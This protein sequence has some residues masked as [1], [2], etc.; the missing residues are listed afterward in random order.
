MKTKRGLSGCTLKMIAVFIMVID[1]FGASIL[2]NFLINRWGASPIGGFLKSNPYYLSLIVQINSVIRKIGRPAFPIFCFFIVEGF[3][4]TRN[5][6][7]YAVRL[8]VFALISELPFD[9]ALY[10][11]FFYWRHQNVYFTLLLGLLLIWYLRDR[12]RY[13]ED[14]LIAVIAACCAA[15]I[16]HVDYGSF[17][18]A[19]IGIYYMLRKMP[20]FQATAGAVLSAWEMPAPIGSLMLLLYNGERG[21]QPKWFFYWFYPVHLFLYYAIGTWVLPAWI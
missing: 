7:K 5:V 21:R 2:E 3:L 6:K 1:H 13:K 11:R 10:G 8:G 18:V 16:L 19:L 15:E 20:V 14:G 12:S 9:L 17:G 4:H